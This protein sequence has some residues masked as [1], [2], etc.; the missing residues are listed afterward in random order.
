MLYCVIMSSVCHNSQH[1]VSSLLAA[2]A[3]FHLTAPHIIIHI[4]QRH[5]HSAARYAC[6]LSAA[7]A[8]R[9]RHGRRAL[10]LST[11]CWPPL[12]L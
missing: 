9:E 1:A 4:W 5:W 2:G 6:Q 8:L 7:Q 3:L 11:C 10:R 12:T